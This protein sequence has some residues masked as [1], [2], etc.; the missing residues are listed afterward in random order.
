MIGPRAIV[1]DLISAR[2]LLEAQLTELLDQ[3]RFD[4]EVLAWVSM[5]LK[6]SHDDE[7]RYHEDA[8]RR[9]QAE[10][11]R[12]QTGIDVMYIDK[13]DGRIDLGFFERTAGE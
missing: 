10:Y 6:L 3:L 2:I 8:I 13:L 5:A 7:K 4:D 9:I 11:D 12:L 1:L